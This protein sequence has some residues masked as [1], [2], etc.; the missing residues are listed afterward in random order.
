MNLGAAHLNRNAIYL[1]CFGVGLASVVLDLAG[2]V[3][4]RQRSRW[5]IAGDGSWLSRAKAMGPIRFGGPQSSPGLPSLAA[6]LCWLGATGY[7]LTLGSVFAPALVLVLSV[8]SGLSGAGLVYWLTSKVFLQREPM[9]EP[10]DMP[11]VGVLGRV[12]AAVP[13]YGLGEMLYVQG[14][15]RRSMPIC[16]EDGVPIQCQAEVVVLRYQRGVGYVRRWDEMQQSLLGDDAPA[17]R[18]AD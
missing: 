18:N 14:G 4:L 5:G 13:R 2:G 7:L 17:T 16:A 10:P 11:M 6:F 12:S 9:L 1:T 15:A 3:F 8:L